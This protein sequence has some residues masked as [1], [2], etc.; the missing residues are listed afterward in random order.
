MITYKVDG[1]KDETSPPV[2]VWLQ[3]G[4]NGEMNL[5]AS[6]DDGLGFLVAY[7]DRD[8]YFNLYTGYGPQLAELGFQVDA[9]GQVKIH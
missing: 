2:R 3:V 9:K 6:G 7:L 8:G 1:A 4:N 5:R